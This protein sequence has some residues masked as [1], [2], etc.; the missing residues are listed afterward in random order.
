MSFEDLKEAGNKHFFNS[1]YDEAIACYSEA[2]N[3]QPRSHVLFSNRSVAYSKLKL[4]QKALDDSTQCIKLAPEFARG[5]LRKASACN[6]LGK[7]AKLFQRP[8]KGTNFVLVREFVRIVL[9]SGL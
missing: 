1:E 4:Y 7:L 9:M 2:L 3:L 6:G 5:Y 8:K